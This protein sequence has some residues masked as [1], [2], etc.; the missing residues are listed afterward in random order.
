MKAKVLVAAC[1]IGILSAQLASATQYK[2]DLGPTGSPWVVITIEDTASGEVQLTIEN[3]HNLPSPGYTAEVYL[4]VVD[5]FVGN[6]N[7]TQT[8][9]NGQ[10]ADPTFAQ[11]L[12]TYE[13]NGFGFFDILVLFEDIDW[14]LYQQQL[15]PY[16]ET[17]LFGPG[18]SVT[19][20]VTSSVPGLQASDFDLLSTDPEKAA[21][22]VDLT[23]P[24]QQPPTLSGAWLAPGQVFYVPDAGSTASLLM[25]GVLGLGWLARRRD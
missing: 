11:A 5:A 13:A 25:M 9:K 3:T 20:L 15:Q 16:D 2:F 17:K 1:S 18:E 24:Q 22:F 4:N 6:L 10:F 12:D 19:Y 8:V 14:D 21:A 23:D 7:F